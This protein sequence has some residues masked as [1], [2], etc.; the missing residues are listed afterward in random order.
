[1]QVWIFPG[2]KGGDYMVEI[3]EH[4]SGSRPTLIKGERYSCDRCGSYCYPGGFKDQGLY[5]YDGEELCLECLL[6]TLDGEEIIK[7]IEP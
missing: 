4:I 5:E 7:K 1:M 2:V 3:L 6:E